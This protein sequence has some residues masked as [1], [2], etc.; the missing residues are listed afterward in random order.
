MAITTDLGARNLTLNRQISNTLILKVVLLSHL[1]VMAIIGLNA[2]MNEITPGYDKLSFII[3][4]RGR[5]AISFFR[6]CNWSTREFR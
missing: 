3:D 1:E 2:S 5:G 4:E 6:D